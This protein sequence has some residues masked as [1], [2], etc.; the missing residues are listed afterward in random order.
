MDWVD[1]IVFVA[2]AA[3]IFVMAAFAACF[4]LNVTMDY[5]EEEFGKEDSHDKNS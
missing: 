4:M 1:L 2:V 3:F 5:C